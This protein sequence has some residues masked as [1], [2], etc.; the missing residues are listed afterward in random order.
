MAKGFK[1]ITD[2]DFAVL[3]Q[4]EQQFARIVYAKYLQGVGSTALSWM[5]EW[6]KRFAGPQS[7][8]V[9]KNCA[10]CVAS[11]LRDTGRIYFA[12]KALREQEAKKAADVAI[13]DKPKH[14]P[15]ATSEQRKKARKV[16]AKKADT[17]KSE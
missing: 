9:N 14:T 6:W 2:A 3:A 16:T 13:S 1:R 12:E 8:K 17:A 7:P 15:A 5:E 10:D 11:F 4:W